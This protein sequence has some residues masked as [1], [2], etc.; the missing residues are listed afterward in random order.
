MD[1]C[2]IMFLKFSL[3]FSNRLNLAYLIL[4]EGLKNEEEYFRF[5]H[6]QASGITALD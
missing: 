2:D 3:N 5:I 6:E 1:M 4:R